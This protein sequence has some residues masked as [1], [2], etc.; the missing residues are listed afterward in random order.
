MYFSEWDQYDYFI[1]ANRRRTTGLCAQE[2]TVN[3]NVSE[4]AGF[5]I[6]EINLD[7][8]YQAIAKTRVAKRRRVLQRVLGNL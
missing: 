3:K 1:Q 6:E 7:V 8:D 5:V 4:E 2:L